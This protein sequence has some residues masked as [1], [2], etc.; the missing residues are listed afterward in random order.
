MKYIQF[1]LLFQRLNI[2][3]RRLQQAYDN[4]NV[5]LTVTNINKILIL[6]KIDK[7]YISR[8][9]LEMD[10]EHIENLEDIANLQ[11]DFYRDFPKKNKKL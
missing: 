8:T 9:I 6:N 10:H 2:R 11:N 1:R 7:E 3:L 4:T 5:L